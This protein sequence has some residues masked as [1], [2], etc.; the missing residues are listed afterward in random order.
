LFPS[1]SHFKSNASMPASIA[2]P[3]IICHAGS[4]GPLQ[5]VLAPKVCL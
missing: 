1:L 4:N 5:L 2:F 3:S